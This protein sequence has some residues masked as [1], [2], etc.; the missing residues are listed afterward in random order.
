LKVEFTYYPFPQI[1][2]PKLL[3]G[4][5]I[6]SLKDIAVNKVFTIAQNP[7]GRD[8]FDTYFILKKTHWELQ[9]LLKLCRK[10]FDY[11]IDYLQF[12]ANLMRV[13]TLK[14]DPILTDYMRNIRIQT[15]K[16]FFLQQ[17]K[18]LKEKF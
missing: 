1:E 13:E 6:D 15:I 2:K 10:K 18:K 8:F 12:G 4:L 3:E 9:E 11:H 17:A 14:D 7:R 16:N 5:R